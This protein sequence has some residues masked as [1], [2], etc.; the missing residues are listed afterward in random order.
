MIKNE[1]YISW[2]KMETRLY[3]NRK[4]L[5]VP[6]KVSLPDFER[7]DRTCYLLAHMNCPKDDTMC[8]YVGY[9]WVWV[10]AEV[11]QIFNTF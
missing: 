4:Y 11:D 1:K 6:W 2:N 5:S 9:R 3:K 10:F 8:C 7:S